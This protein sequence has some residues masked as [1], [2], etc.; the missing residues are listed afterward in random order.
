[1]E[2]AR[3]SRNRGASG[4]A[5]QGTET[6]PA[7]KRDRLVSASTS[8]LRT[9]SSLP[10]FPTLKTARLAGVVLTLLPSRTASGTWFATTSSRPL[11]SI[12]KVR[13]EN[14]RIFK[15]GKHDQNFYRV[16]WETLLRGVPWQGQPTSAVLTLPPL[17]VRWLTPAD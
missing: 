9:N 14:P 17:A 12:P 15:S 8:Y 1:M 4:D 16:M 5:H 11:G 3:T 7:Q 6:S 2:A 13:G 10:S